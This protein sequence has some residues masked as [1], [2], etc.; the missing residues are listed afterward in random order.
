MLIETKNR[1]G[2][3]E[4]TRGAS[5]KRSMRYR[6]SEGELSEIY[7]EFQR[8]FSPDVLKALVGSDILHG[9]FLSGND[10]NSL[11]Y[12]LE[13]GTDSE[14]FGSIAGGSAFK[15]GLFQRQGSGKWTA[16]SPQHPV[17]LTEGEAIS[18]GQKIRDCIVA[19]YQVICEFYPE[20]E[21]DYENLDWKLNE[22]LGKYVNYSW[23]RKYYHMMFPD[24]FSCFYSEGYQRHVL[25][26]LGIHP[27]K[28]YYGRSGQLALFAKAAGL[29]AVY[30]AEECNEQFGS[31]KHFYRLGSSNDKGNYAMHWQEKG[32]IAIGWRDLGDLRE[33]AKQGVLDR[34]MIAEQLGRIYYNGNASTSSRKACEIKNFYEAN[35]DSVFVVMDGERLLALVDNTS[36][37][38][39]DPSEPM[40]HCKH[41]TWHMC[42]AQGEKLP[43]TEGYL[44]TC[45]ELKKENNLLHIYNLYYQMKEHNG[46]VTEEIIPQSDRHSW[47]LTW[48]PSVWE[49]SDFLDAVRATKEKADWTEEWRCANSHVRTGDR[50][51]LAM[52]GT[53]DNG[54]IASG[55]AA[56]EPFECEH[57][58]AQ[59][60]SDGQRIRRIKIRFDR[61][62]DYRSETILPQKQLQEE[63]PNQKWNPQGSGIAIK[64]EYCER[65]EE[66]WSAVQSNSE[67]SMRISSIGEKS[68]NKEN[69]LEQ[70]FMTSEEYDELYHLLMYKKN[71]IL[72]GAPGVGKTFMAKKLAYSIIG[73]K[74][75]S[76]I[77]V[78]QFHQSYSYEDFIMGYKPSNDGFELKNGV[79]YNFCKMAEKSSSKNPYFFIIDEIN[80]G[81]LSKIFGE[82]LMLLE[83]DKRGAEHRIRLAYRDELFFVPENVYIIGMM[84]TADR[85][86]AMMDYALRRRFSFFEIEPAFDTPMFKRYL[87]RYIHTDRKSV[88]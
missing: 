54:I 10:N 52:L 50:V 41:G 7:K 21:G 53:K 43:E 34:R 25:Y 15:Y 8:R 66:I 33:Y 77:D 79:F 76:H 51:F 45:T 63:F 58:D 49:W 40:A 80:R 44:S 35:A 38:Y 11:C 48:N 62:L 36:S 88:V 46:S 1:Q 32:I 42:F 55:F 61:I 64:D 71:I 28:T 4:R 29:S 6:K 12:W 2:A 3:E 85:S 18:Y 31:V 69:F 65:L 16:G 5:F 81:N 14:L 86:L 73:E 23:I 84:N 68:Y 56:G 47:L 72:Q 83:G 24:K 39:Y 67:T 20:V 87:E 13:Y 82:L 70:V 75:D 19:G 27:L 22:I 37:Y 57:W 17:E 26:G 74:D 78:I 9:I 59:K 60:A 30:F